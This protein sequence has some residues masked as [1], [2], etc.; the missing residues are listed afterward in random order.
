MPA[1]ALPAQSVNAPVFVPKIPIPTSSPPPVSAPNAIQYLHSQSSYVSRFTPL[2]AHLS[3]CRSSSSGTGDLQE[4]LT[5]YDEYGYPLV[6]GEPH[7]DTLVG[8]MQ[9]VGPLIMT[10]VSSIHLQIRW[11]LTHTIHHNSWGMTVLTLWTYFTPRKPLLF[12]NR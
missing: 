6:N 11:K 10:R 2:P 1:P 9:A 8:Q 3:I 7:I 12:A 4:D 5:A